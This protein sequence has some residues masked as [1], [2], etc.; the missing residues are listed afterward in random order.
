MENLKILAISDL[1]GYL[2]KIEDKFDILFICGDICPAHDH[3]YAY[4]KEWIENEFVTWINNLPYKDAFSVVVM[5]WGNHDFIGEKMREGDNNHLK[6]L[7]NGRLHILKNDM[8]SVEYLS[9]DG[10]KTLYVAGTPYCK[11]FGNWAFMVSDESLREKYSK[12][13]NNLDV[14]LTHDSPRVNNLGMISQ[15]WNSGVDAGNKILDEWIINNNP[16]YLFSGHIH[17]GN[18][19]FEKIGNTWMANVSLV[20][21]RYDPTH[22]ALGFEIDRETKELIE[23]Y[24]V[25]FNEFDRF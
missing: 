24:P 25:L 15:G 4:Q 2:P 1:H 8:L 22:P 19:V 10:V 16:K 6:K 23:W 17:S 21:E 9:D 12:L 11:I 14:L 5:T 20:D 18:H 7:T 13:P 3:Y